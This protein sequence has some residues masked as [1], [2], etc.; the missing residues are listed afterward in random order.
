MRSS[1]HTDPWLNARIRLGSMPGC[2]AYWLT[3]VGPPGLAERVGHER[4]FEMRWH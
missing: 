4:L 2:F 3:A 1:G